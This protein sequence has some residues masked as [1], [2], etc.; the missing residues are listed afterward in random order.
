[1]EPGSGGNYMPAKLTIN[2]FP[3]PNPECGEEYDP[4]PTNIICYVCNS[5]VT[6]FLSRIVTPEFGSIGKIVVA[7]VFGRS[8][9]QAARILETLSMIP[10]ADV[11]VKGYFARWALSLRL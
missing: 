1:M 4:S 7:R 3:C 2:S 11:E 6:A 5:G 8:R 9:E 10:P